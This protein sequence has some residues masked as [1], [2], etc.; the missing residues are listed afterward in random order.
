M[1]PARNDVAMPISPNSDQ[2]RTADAGNTT[3]RIG[4]NSLFRGRSEG[5]SISIGGTTGLAGASSG[6]LCVCEGNALG[7][8]GWR[9]ADGNRGDAVSLAGGKEAGAAGR[10]V[11]IFGNGA[12]GS[13]SVQGA[14]SVSS[15][16]EG[17]RV[18]LW[19]NS[20]STRRS[21][22]RRSIRSAGMAAA[23]SSTSA[24]P[25]DFD[26]ASVDWERPDAL[27]TEL[28]SGSATAGESG[29]G[30]TRSALHRGQDTIEPAFEGNEARSWLH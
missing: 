3:S 29:A 14:G 9:V 19:K 25:V 18:R 1:S 15:G 13:V 21:S 6:G 8:S 10:P 22:G 26:G 20:A 4:W 24:S 5:G 30:T 23:L 11:S 2:A 7:N 27:P 17:A 12:T 16:R 28:P